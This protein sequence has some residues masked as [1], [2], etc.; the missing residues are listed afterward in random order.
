MKAFRL[1]GMALVAMCLCM[2]FASCS[3]EDVVA[4]EDPQEEKYVTVGLGCT[5]EFLEFSDSP[6]S[7]A[8][9]DELYGIQVYSL[10]ETN[11]YYDNETGEPIVEYDETQYAY[12][13]FTSLENVKIRL[14]EGQEYKFEVSIVI[15]PFNENT[16]WSKY[17]GGYSRDYWFNRSYEEY[18]SEFGSE[19]AY[20][21]DY[22]LSLSHIDRWSIKETQHPYDRYYGELSGYTPTE[23]GSV[24]IDTKRVVYGVKYVTSGLNEGE[25]LK[26]EVARDGNSNSIYLVELDSEINENIY[27][28]DRI[29]KA[30]K[31]IEVWNKNTQK[32][33]YE[34]YTSDKRLTITWNKADGTAVPMGTY[35]VT[36][37]RNVMTTIKIKAENL[38]LDNGITVFKEEVSMAADENIYEIEGGT[39]TEV[40][41]TSG[42]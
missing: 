34:N 5:G 13:M 37:K 9:T 27:T 8:T 20:S 10:T 41:V 36:F 33:E 35:K 25:S 31:G 3:N 22:G 6:L 2:N 18:Y 30:W 15:D 42:N 17:G 39:V 28:F 21:S 40:P 24:E 38:N 11:R 23:N 1:I 19:F 16:E 4:P 7:R 32:Y 26:V 12:G 14:L 29:E